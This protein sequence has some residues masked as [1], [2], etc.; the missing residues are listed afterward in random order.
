MNSNE[1]FKKKDLC[2]SSAQ[3]DEIAIWPIWK[4]IL[5][6][7]IYVFCLTNGELQN[8]YGKLRYV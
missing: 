3:D 6:T 2:F 7:E 4:D 8:S 5:E 1:I